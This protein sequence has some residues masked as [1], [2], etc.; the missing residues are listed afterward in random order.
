MI[1]I[2]LKDSN[3]DSIV[4]TCFVY[5]IQNIS[6]GRK[7]T[8]NL[9]WHSRLYTPFWKWGNWVSRI[10]SDSLS[11]QLGT[12]YPD[13]KS[14]MCEKIHD[15]MYFR[16]GHNMAVKMREISVI[17]K[18]DSVNLKWTQN[19]RTNEISFEADFNSSFYML[20]DW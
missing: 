7:F 4:K 8:D 17:N 18:K 13:N 10:L 6:N 2:D 3:C 12:L 9:A 19:I 5:F 15:F 20:R 14:R 1:T 16:S 11:V